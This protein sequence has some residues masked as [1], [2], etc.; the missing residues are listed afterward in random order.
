MITLYLFSCWSLPFHG[1]A[2]HAEEIDWKCLGEEFLLDFDGI[3][4]D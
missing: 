1:F 4:D 3:F 2:V